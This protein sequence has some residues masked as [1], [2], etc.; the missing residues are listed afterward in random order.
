MGLLV[1]PVEMDGLVSRPVRREQPVAVIHRD[2]P[3]AGEASLTPARLAEHHLIV[4]PRGQSAGSHDVV[5]ALF[6]ARPP[7]SVTEIELFGAGWWT[8][9]RN[10][11]FAVMPA[12][13]PVTPEFVRV[14]IEGA[15]D[16]FVSH[17]IWSRDGA[18]AHVDELVDAF[19]AFAAEQ[20]WL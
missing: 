12:G 2:N 13:A 5:L 6:D 17:V 14:P 18:P 11:G 20:G 7:T 10:G 15:R 8:G 1:S 16:D 4:W 3:L 19:S 9:M